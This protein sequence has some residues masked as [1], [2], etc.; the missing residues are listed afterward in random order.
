MTQPLDKYMT[1]DD[2]PRSRSLSELESMS[3]SQTSRGVL[4]PFR[5]QFEQQA[6]TVSRS[7]ESAVSQTE[8]G[9]FHDAWTLGVAKPERAE[10]SSMA[11]FERKAARAILDEDDRIAVPSDDVSDYPYRCICSLVIHCRTGQVGL[12]TGWLVGPRTVVTAGHCVYMHNHGR[13]AAGVDVYPAR[14]GDHRPFRARATRLM[15]VRGWTEQA[16]PE[17]DYGGIEV[18]RDLS[19]IGSFSY[20]ALPTAEL[21]TL[22]AVNVVG[23]PADKPGTMWGHA[24]RLARVTKRQLEYEIDTINGNS[25]GPV[26]AL[27]NDEAIAVGIH[28]YG[29]LARMR[30]L[31]TRI[32][33]GVYANIRDWKERAASS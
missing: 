20:A 10:R 3:F 25:G 14:V 2:T 7:G 5:A 19:D 21:E 15:S 29:N 24:R 27:R 31:A 4:A 28:N 32:T 6:R 11:K 18:D 33:K 1:G 17:S 9:E 30:N 23:Y 22:Q 26:F 8:A 13:W 16:K 12:G